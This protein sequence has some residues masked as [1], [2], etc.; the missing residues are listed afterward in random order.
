MPTTC[1][2]G[3]D[4]LASTFTGWF[5]HPSEPSREQGGNAVNDSEIFS[6]VMIVVGFVALA[7]WLTFVVIAIAQVAR[8]RNIEYLTKVLWVAGIVIFPLI[9]TIAW[10]LFG[11]RTRELERAVRAHI[12]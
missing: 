4:L 9:G 1:W 3:S 8:A 2:I 11:D 5:R 12:N 6:W 10:Y 7:A